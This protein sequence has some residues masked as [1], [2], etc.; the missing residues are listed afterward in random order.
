M[1]TFSGYTATQTKHS[2]PAILNWASKLVLQEYPM[3]TKH[4]WEKLRSGWK[5]LAAVNG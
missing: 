4:D 2:K 5:I 3:M 1:P